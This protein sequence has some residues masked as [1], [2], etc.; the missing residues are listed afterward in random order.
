MTQ[1]KMNTQT[2]GNDLTLRVNDFDLSYDDIGEGKV[3]I[4][5][6]HGFPFDK[7]M[8]KS[9]LDA[10]KA[11]NR[12]IACDIRGFGQSSDEDT[13]LS[14]DLFA[15]DLIDFM[16][17]LRIEKAIICGLSM[18][19]Y[20][21]LNAARRFPDR[22]EALILCD[23]QCNADNDDVKAKRQ[24]AI[25]GIE[26]NGPAEF[27]EKFLLSVF[28]K[29][30]ITKKESLVKDLRKVVNANTPNI[31]INGLNAISQRS[32]TCSVLDKIEVP[33]LIICGRDDQ[34]TPLTQSEAMHSQIEDSVLRIIENAGHVSNL[35]QTED[36]NTQVIDFL[37]ML[38]DS[39]FEKINGKR[40]MA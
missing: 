5:F 12:V 40:R 13:M 23:T 1:T 26:E 2:R 8:W 4:I 39:K 15:E 10:L 7:S 24:S 11:S 27:N 29:D 34:V 31:I 6:L 33:T 28:H 14:I 35:E 22:F 25:E 32:E 9:Q 20:I 16:N 19:G 3:P 37:A 38:S 30:S 17:E 21:T 18:G 36:F